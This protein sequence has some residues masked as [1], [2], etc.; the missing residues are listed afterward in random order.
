M[1][2]TVTGDVFTAE[3]DVLLQG[4]NCFCVWGAGV[5]RILKRDYPLAFK[6]DLVTEEGDVGKL[7]TY[8]SW[9]GPHLKIPNKDVTI[10]NCY[11][12]YDT[13]SPDVRADYNA[14]KWV[15]EKV[16]ED[17]KDKVIGMPFLGAGLAGGDPATI[18][19]IF[20]EVFK[21]SSVDATLYLLPNEFPE[22]ERK[23]Y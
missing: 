2:K 21:N 23:T 6:A 16:A 13:S 14:I 1:F 5:A 7:G 22:V 12:Q 3:L 4:N 17:F 18:L 10:V 15:L 11:T 9:T 19:D 8:S 20:L